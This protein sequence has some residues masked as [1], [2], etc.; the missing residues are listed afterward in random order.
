M[1]TICKLT[2]YFVVLPHL[3][4]LGTIRRVFGPSAGLPS[5]DPSEYDLCEALEKPW[6][7]I[8]D[9]CEAYGVVLR[10]M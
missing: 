4:Q 1:P 7:R 3:L 8:G 10:S 9:L 6:T 2:I 5:R